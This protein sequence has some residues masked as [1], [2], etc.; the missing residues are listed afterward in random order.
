MGVYGNTLEAASPVTDDPVV[1]TIIIT[2]DAPTP[3]D[4]VVVQATVLDGNNNLASVMLNWSVDE[5]NQPSITM[6]DDGD[7]LYSATIPVL[8]GGTFVSLSVTAADADGASDISDIITYTV[9]PDA[10]PKSQRLH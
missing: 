7:N 1:A 5:A 6:A 8:P 10:L 9:R 3:S 2:P 4:E